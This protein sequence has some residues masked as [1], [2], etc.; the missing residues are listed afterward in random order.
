MSSVR[1]PKKIENSTGSDKKV[2]VAERGTIR[3]K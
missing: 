3:V 2:N 1:P